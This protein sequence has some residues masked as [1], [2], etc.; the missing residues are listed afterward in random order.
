MFRRGRGG[1]RR[2]IARQSVRT[3]WADAGGGWRV[4]YVRAVCV[5]KGK[6]TFRSRRAADATPRGADTVLRP[7]STVPLPLHTCA[8]TPLINLYLASYRSL[9]RLGWPASQPASQPAMQISSDGPGQA[10]EPSASHRPTATGIAATRNL[11]SSKA[12]PTS[13]PRSPPAPAPPWPRKGGEGD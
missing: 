12:R 3:A 1:R 6:V 5:G 2:D 13:Q 9:R 4:V 11:T 10:S 7:S 8:H